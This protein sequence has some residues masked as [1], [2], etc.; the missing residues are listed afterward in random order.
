MY[1]LLLIAGLFAAASAQTWNCTNVLDW[2]FF[3]AKVTANNLGGLGPN[4]QDKE[5]IRYSGVHDKFDMVVTV[6]PGYHTV[7]NKYGLSGSTNN[8]LLGKFG[9]VNTA[10]SSQADLK[11]RLVDTGTDNLF[12]IDKDEKIQFSVY[13][14]DSAK[15]DVAEHEFVEFKT[16]VASYGVHE[17]TTV[18]VFGQGSDGTLWAQS[19]RAGTGADNPTNPL[20]MTPTQEVSKI[21]VTY[22]GVAEW[23]IV[24]GDKG[25]NPKYGRNGLF[26]GRSQGDCA[27]I[28]IADWTLHDNLKYNNLGGMGPVTSDPAELRYEKVFSSGSEM[29]PVDLVVKVADGSPYTVAN[30]DS[31]GLSPASPAKHA[32]MGEINIKIGTQTTFDFMFVKSGTNEPYDLSNVMFSVYDLDE[33]KTGLGENHEY[34]EFVTPVTDWTLTDDTIVKKSGSINGADGI[35][36]FRSTEA[37]TLADN[38]TNPNA[39]TDG[40]KSRSVTVWYSSMS[41]F[42]I[43]LGHSMEKDNGVNGGRNMLFAGPGIFC[44]ARDYATP[45]HAE[46]LDLVNSAHSNDSSSSVPTAAFVVIGVAALMVGVVAL[47]AQ[48]KKKHSDVVELQELQTVSQLSYEAVMVKEDTL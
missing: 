15:K 21:S 12:K 39:L 7:P 5:E 43:A 6:G 34:V 8:G 29:Q 47:V 17:N 23:N 22:V 4:F 18:Q 48:Y 11:F 38:P 13:D 46:Q 35:L 28:G 36:K 41:K 40:M 2:N 30:T 16:P 26:A 9:Q 32:Q 14:L 33:K 37:G 24:Y 42:Q 1:R 31:N 19:G 25:G 27:C 10:G 44:P 45:L 3:D 20:K